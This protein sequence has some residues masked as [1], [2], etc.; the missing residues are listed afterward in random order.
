MS[1]HK[2]KADDAT[3][4]KMSCIKPGSSCAH[5]KSDQSTMK[6]HLKLSNEVI[7]DYR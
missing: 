3:T 2:E 1:L 6:H 7:S 4:S 5:V